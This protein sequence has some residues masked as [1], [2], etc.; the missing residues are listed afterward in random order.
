MKLA[1]PATVEWEG[2]HGRTSPIHIVGSGKTDLELLA[3]KTGHRHLVQGT[4]TLDMSVVEMVLD[5]TE[6][7]S[8]IVHVNGQWTEEGMDA[9]LEIENGFLQGSWFPHPIESV[10]SEISMLYEDVQINTWNSVVGGGAVSLV[11]SVATT[12]F[13]PSQY[14]LELSMNQSRIQLLDWLP[15]VVGSGD[16][17]VTGSADLPLITGSVVATEMTFVDRIGWEGALLT[18]APEALTGATEEELEPYFEYAIDFTAQDTIRIRNNLADMSA[19]AD[20]KF[21]GNMASPGMLGSITLTEG[22]RVLFKE[23]DFDVLRGTLRYEDASTFDPLLDIALETSVITPE[24]EVEIRY[25]ITGLYSDWQTHT[26]STPALPQADI[27]ALLLFGMTRRELETEGGLG[28]ALAIEGSDLVFSK[29]GASQR[30]VEVGSGIFQ[31]ELLRLD[32]VDIVSGP[33][34][35]NSAYV[36]SALRLLAEKDIGNGTLRLEQNITD[37][38][39]VFVSWEQRLTQ[40]LYTRLYWSSLQQGRTINGNGAVGAEFEVQWELD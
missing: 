33:T 9:Q 35:R 22:G 4:G 8:G 15:P 10:Y 30:F 13:L 23:R 14:N 1:S 19:S 20:L 24:R 6:R 11:G 7:A 28:A 12:D 5:G 34:D 29:F 25:F 18:F 39:D 16:F 40:R 3:E 37:T 38:T 27:N 26:A 31:S 17:R 2:V 36:S 21:V 32:R